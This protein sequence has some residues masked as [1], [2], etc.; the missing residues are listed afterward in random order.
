MSGSEDGRCFLW[1][2]EAG[3]ASPTQ[4]PR[5]SLGGEA[6]L[7]VAWNSIFHVAG[8]GVMRVWKCEG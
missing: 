6:V 1:D 5:F 8:E 2:A 4:L 7:A 3:G